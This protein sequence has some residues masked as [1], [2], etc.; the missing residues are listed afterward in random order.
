MSLQPSNV[1][2]TTQRRVYQNYRNKCEQ[3]SHESL[4]FFLSEQLC[5]LVIGIDQKMV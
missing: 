5:P 3:R 4:F 2:W 1:R